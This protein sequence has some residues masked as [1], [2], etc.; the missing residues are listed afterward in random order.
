MVPSKE[1]LLTKPASHFWSKSID[2]QG[3]KATGFV[4]L[5]GPLPK[6]IAASPP[7]LGLAPEDGPSEGGFISLAFF[8]AGISFTTFL[9]SLFFDSAFRFA[10]ASLC[11]FLR[12]K[13][14]AL[15]CGFCFALALGDGD[16]GESFGDVFGEL[17]GAFDV[18]S[19]LG[20]A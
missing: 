20:A 19:F 1:C 7:G 11:R 10:A 18:V 5:S 13:A 4:K 3:F 15:G 16:C 6:P 2:A 9:D 12:A 17:F 8:F 14:F